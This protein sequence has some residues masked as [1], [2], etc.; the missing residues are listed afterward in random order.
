[1][2]QKA[3]DCFIRK[4]SE[5]KGSCFQGFMLRK[6]EDGQCSIERLHNRLY[7]QRQNNKTKSK[8]SPFCG[9]SVLQ[10]KNHNKPSLQNNPTEPLTELQTEKQPK[11]CHGQY[12]QKTKNII[13]NRPDRAIFSTY[14]QS[15]IFVVSSHENH[16]SPHGLICYR[17]EVYLLYL[18]AVT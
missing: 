16:L 2:G 13:K 10:T 4:G 12:K 9:G 15:V 6:R 3:H 14:L 7:R 1:M 11:N 5:V 18:C 17:K 8:V